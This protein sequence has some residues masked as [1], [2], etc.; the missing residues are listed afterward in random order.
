MSAFEQL[1]KALFPEEMAAFD[2][3]DKTGVQFA[4]YTDASTA[5]KILDPNFPVIWMR[6]ALS[7]ND[8]SEISHGVQ[9]IYAVGRSPVGDEFLR[10]VDGVSNQISQKIGNDIGQWLADLVSNCFLTCL[11]VHG[12]DK[13]R[14]PA[15]EKK[16]GR[17]SMWRA[18]GRQ[19]GV[20]LILNGMKFNSPSEALGASIYPVE[21]EEQLCFQVKL[22]KLTQRIGENSKLIESFEQED[23]LDVI[24]TGFVN[25]AL[26]S[27][28][29]AFEEE[30]EWR[31]VHIA[32]R[33]S[34]GALQKDLVECAG[35]PQ[36]VLKIPLVKIDDDLDL[37]VGNILDQILVG[38]S[39]NADLVR[40]A[41]V[42]RL[43]EFGINDAHNKVF[44]TDVPLRQ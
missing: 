29:V 11:S 41:L 30:E 1:Q 4:Y 37:S 2:L 31:V 14:S 42:Q 36:R 5:L 9:A 39:A 33:E 12:A 34:I 20:A 25:W 13:N 23:F 15:Y 17:L 38:P 7:M 22:R 27:K 32:E 10:A 24:R 35:V 8:S 44:K 18:Y 28:H 43:H 19:S 16:Y 6:N 3:L 26:C 21:Y 40:D